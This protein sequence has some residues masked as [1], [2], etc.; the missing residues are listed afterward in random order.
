MSQ[1]FGTT[2]QRVLTDREIAEDILTSHKYLS[3]YYYA[4]AILES[5]DPGLRSTFQQIHND[6]QSE[7]KQ[8]FDYLNARGW[9][10]PR[11]A[12]AQSVTELRNIA[13]ESRQIVSAL[14][15]GG[16]KFGTTGGV[17]GQTVIG[18]TGIDV[19]TGFGRPAT[20]GIA[21]G[22]TTGGTWG[23]TAGAASVGQTWQ[24]TA[25]QGNLQAGTG[26]QPSYSQPGQ[27]TG[28]QAG[29][30][31]SG[32]GPSSVAQ[33]ARWGGQPSW[34]G[35]QSGG[36]SGHGGVTAGTAGA[37]SAGQTWQ[38][39]GPSTWQAGTGWQPS[40][41]QPGH[42]TGTQA[43]EGQSGMGPSSLAQW[44]R[45]GG[46]PSWTGTQSGS[47]IG[48]TGVAGATGITGGFQSTGA[49]AQSDI[50]NR[51]LS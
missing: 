7:A 44:A 20:Q 17:T 9:Y 38:S 37:A 48:Q 5:M 36:W 4:P 3:N 28:T 45:W 33:W 13:E 35:L 2:G 27:W 40:Y 29:E 26:W 42:W 50:R 43:G 22:G 47:L 51:E 1:M 24:S 19:Q 18:Q 14:S 10:R 6:T 30:G 23:G 49:Y 39:A 8:V 11:Q 16:Q 15:S 34:T 31:Q 21:M 46:Q 41:S 12:D 25:G 32:M